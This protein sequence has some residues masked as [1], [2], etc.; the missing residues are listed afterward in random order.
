MTLRAL[1]PIVALLALAGCAPDVLPRRFT[2][3][4]LSDPGAVTLAVAVILVVCGLTYTLAPSG[5]ASEG[6]AGR[7]AIIAV[8]SWTFVMI[9]RLVWSIYG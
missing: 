2:P 1:T 3:T 9:L 6:R 4:S 7:I 8:V 5:G